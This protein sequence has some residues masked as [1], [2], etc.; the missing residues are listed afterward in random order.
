MSAPKNDWL[1]E[2]LSKVLASVNQLIDA[3]FLTRLLLKMA[4][5][6]CTHSKWSAL[7]IN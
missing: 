6:K 7:E 4:I 1:T 2:Q 5:I 3:G